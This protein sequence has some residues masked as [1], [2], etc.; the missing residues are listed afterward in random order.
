M[1]EFVGAWFVGGES[2]HYFSFSLFLTGFLSCTSIA[3]MVD[4]PVSLSFETHSLLENLVVPRVVR[5]RPSDPGKKEYFH[6]TG[7]LG[8]FQL[9]EAKAKKILKAFKAQFPGADLS[10]LM[11]A[12]QLVS[13]YHK[14]QVPQSDRV[15]SNT[16]KRVMVQAAEGFSLPDSVIVVSA[17]TEAPTGNGSEKGKGLR[18]SAKK[19]KKESTTDNVEGSVVKI[20]GEPGLRCAQLF[21][22]FGA[23][24]KDR[25]TMQKLLDQLLEDAPSCDY[26]AMCDLYRHLVVPVHDKVDPWTVEQNAEHAGVFSTDRLEADKDITFPGNL[27]AAAREIDAEDAEEEAMEEES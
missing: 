2:A 11:I 25:D 4:H 9:G 7:P 5:T 23:I 1:D 19:P 8:A 24:C 13:R 22:F 6:S 12:P 10:R 14:Y 27:L 15:F 18:D 26:A 3:I 21:V 20:V 17:F 16:Y